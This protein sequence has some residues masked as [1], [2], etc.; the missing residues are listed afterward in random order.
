MSRNARIVSIAHYLPERRISNEQ[1]NEHFSRLGKPE[2]VGKFAAST[3]I[4][5]RWYAPDDW[6]TSDLALPAAREALRRA[7]RKP[8]DVDL[9][10]LGTDS[11]DYTTPSTS[12][13]LQHKLG[14]TQAGTFDVVCACASFPTA[15]TS[16][17]GILATNPGFRTIL[18]I[19]AYMMRK[20]AHPDDPTVFFYGDGAGAA[21]VEPGDK[22]G[23][24]GSAFLAD[25]SYSDCWG[26]FSGGTAEPATE[27]SVRAGRTNV[28]LVKRYP[29]E[30]NDEGWPKLFHQLAKQNDF[31]VDDVDQVIFTQ[32]RKETILQAADT[33]GLPRE[34]AHIIMDKWGYTGSACIPMALS[35]AMEQGKVKDNDLVVMIGSG[36]GYNQAAVAIRM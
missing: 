9:I 33:I 16:A 27:E 12:V 24:I 1:L 14:A 29:P 10:I 31:T 26:I 23:Y 13:V 19:G 20:L 36:V 11:P 17:A 3:G 32:V 18:V 2:V 34:K 4:E 5:Q 22:P 35:D 30:I 8:E 21:V 6:A 25:G 15:L 28:R 7:G